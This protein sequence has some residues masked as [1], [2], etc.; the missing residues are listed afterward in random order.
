MNTYRKPQSVKISPIDKKITTP[1][2]MWLSVNY[3]KYHTKIK[4]H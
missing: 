3:I 4:Y 2:V 1:E